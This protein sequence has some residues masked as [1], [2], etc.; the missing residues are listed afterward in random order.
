[1]YLYIRN[2]VATPNLKYANSSSN[3]HVVMMVE[4]LK[5]MKKRNRKFKKNRIPDARSAELKQTTTAKRLLFTRD[6]S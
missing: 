4:N 5:T 2:K 6:M 3:Y 1:M